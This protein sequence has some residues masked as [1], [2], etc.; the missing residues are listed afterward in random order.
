M[1]NRQY[2][3]IGFILRLTTFF[4]VPKGG[5]DIRLVYSLIDCGINES[6]WGPKLWMPYVENVLDTATHS[7]WFGDVDDAEIFHHYK[8]SEKPQP[9]L[10]VDLYRTKRKGRQ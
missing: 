5:S 4:H 9:Y 7:S 2:I 8:L 3:A 10:G 6:L 1:Q